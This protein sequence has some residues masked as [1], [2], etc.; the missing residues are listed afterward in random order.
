V[1]RKMLKGKATWPHPAKKRIFRKFSSSYE[2]RIIQ[3]LSS[4]EERQS[5]LSKVSRRAAAKR[6]FLPF[7]QLF[8]FARSLSPPYRSIPRS[9][10]RRPPRRR[11]SE[12]TGANRKRRYRGCVNLPRERNYYNS[13]RLPRLRRWCCWVQGLG[14]RPDTLPPSPRQLPPPRPRDPPS[15][16]TPDLPGI[17]PVKGDL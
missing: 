7:F 2:I 1:S 12:S 13:S 10:G 14:C 11:G 15:T 17:A 9:P 6:A 3:I 8:S 16:R 4:T 5:V